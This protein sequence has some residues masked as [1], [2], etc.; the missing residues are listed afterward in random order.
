M[1][2]GKPALLT[3]WFRPAANV[4]ECSA[5]VENPKAF[6]H[7]IGPDVVRRLAA[8]TRKAWAKFDDEAFVKGVLPRLAPLELKARI[9]FVTA[10]WAERLPPSYA[11]ALPI[12][13]ATM[14]PPLTADTQV[15][16]GG[17]YHWLHAHFVET[18]GLEDLE[19]SLAAMVQITQR[20][21][22][23]FC[24][25]PFLIRHP[26]RTLAFLASVRAHESPH[27]RRW[28]SE[29]TRPRLPWGARLTSF[30]ED[31]SPVLELITPLRADASLYVRNSVANNLN[32]IAKD[33]PRLVV[34][35]VRR[36][37]S[38][39]DNP[40]APWIAKRALRQLVKAGDAEALGVL[41]F[42]AKPKVKLVSLAIDKPSLEIGD[43]IEFELALRSSANESVN[44][45][46]AIEYQ[47][48]RGKIA[49]K[50]FKLKVVPLTKGKLVALRKRHSFRL[51][52][53]RTY[54]PG[55]HGITVLVNGRPLGSARF[56]LR[57]STAR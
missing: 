40:H 47:M 22:A 55:A 18:R 26:A 9:G 44:V 43:S 36:W 29:G 30:I 23:E 39:K 5:L 13:L 21:T 33:H 2:Q 35:T 1:A 34:K 10:A 52:T 28:V 51:I 38:E 12:V 16:Q 50:V 54:H 37:L 14:G 57:A 27:V 8:A 7:Q 6:K 17:F 42:D 56:E 53:T 20:G 11:K 41:G 48:A 3:S 4:P 25:R 45:D 49:R 15:S 32:D 31:P 19:A 46:Y 24:V